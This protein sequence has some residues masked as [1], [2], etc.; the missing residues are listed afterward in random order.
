MTQLSTCAR[1]HQWMRSRWARDW[2]RRN[3]RPVH[4]G[5]AG[6]IDYSTLTLLRQPIARR[7]LRRLH[8]R[9]AK[10]ADARAAGRAAFAQAVHALRGLPHVIDSANTDL[11]AGI[12]LGQAKGRRRRAFGSYLSA[13]S[14]ACCCEPTATSS[15]SR[16]RSSSSLRPRRV[17]RNPFSSAEEYGDIDL[18]AMV[19]ASWWSVGLRDRLPR[20]LSA[21]LKL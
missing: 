6:A 15:R 8:I 12:E 13:S 16:L 20:S 4:A 18:L 1:P 19:T 9:R 14:A 11:V 17:V 10:I 21:R 2:R 7:G 3:P 5:T